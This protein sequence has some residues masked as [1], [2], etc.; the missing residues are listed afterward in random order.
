MIRR[1]PRSTLFPYTTL[2]RSGPVGLI[3][4]D[5]VVVHI[6][7]GNFQL[8]GGRDARGL[9]DVPEPDGRTD[10]DVEPAL[11]VLGAF[12][13]AT[14]PVEGLGA[15]TYGIQSRGLVDPGQCAGLDPGAE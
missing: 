14:P 6:L 5:V 12:Q 4:M 8:H 10:G 2:F 11:C 15:H 3:Q 1:P 13:G 9:G 7:S